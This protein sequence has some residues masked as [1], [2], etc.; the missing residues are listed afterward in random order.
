MNRS[1]LLKALIFT[2]AVMLVSGPVMAEK[3]IWKQ[4]QDLPAVGTLD[5]A[6]VSD[7]LADYAQIVQSLNVD[8]VIVYNS[9]AKLMEVRRQLMQYCVEQNA[10]IHSLSVFSEGQPGQFQL[11]NR[12]VSVDKLI[13]QKERLAK[14]QANSN[15]QINKNRSFRILGLIANNGVLQIFSEQAGAGSSG[16]TLV[17]LLSENTGLTVFASDDADLELEVNAGLGAYQNVLRK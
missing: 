3:G 17:E 16:Q 4:V 6:L 5:V 13:Q 1:L 8:K 14:R 2:V 9:Q 11:I 10:R 12:T 15:K 7:G